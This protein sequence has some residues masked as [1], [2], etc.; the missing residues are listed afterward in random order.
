MIGLP[1]NCLALAAEQI[2]AAAAPFETGQISNSRRGLLTYGEASTS[3]MPISF[4]KRAN[5]LPTEHLRAL[6]VTRAYCSSV[7][8]WSN[9]RRRASVAQKEGPGMPTQRCRRNSGSVASSTPEVWIMPLGITSP[10]T[11]RTMS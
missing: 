8:P 9:M 3:L 5:G 1:V 4:W 7:V 10:P 6:T 2:T 11:T